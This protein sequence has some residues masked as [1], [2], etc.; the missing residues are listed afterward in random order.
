MKRII[1][2]IIAG[3]VLICSL[4]SVYVEVN[5]FLNPTHRAIADYFWAGFYFI[6]IFGSL[7][8]WWAGKKQY[9]FRTN[10]IF[11]ILLLSVVI[12]FSDNGPALLVLLWLILIAW[13]IGKKFLDIFKLPIE[14]SFGES[15]IFSIG[16]GMIG[17]VLLTLGL[18]SFH[19]LQ[20]FLPIPARF[21]NLLHPIVIFIVLFILSVLFIPNLFKTIRPIFTSAK[22]SFQ[23]LWRSGEPGWVPI[24]F[25]FLSI[26]GI[27]GILLALSPTIRFDALTYHLTVPARYIEARGMVPIPELW[28]SYWAHYAE[29]LYTLAMI[30]VGQPLPSLLHFTFGLLTISLVFLLGKRLG[31]TSVGALAALLFFSIPVVSYEAGTPYIDLMH[32]FYILFAVYAII[33]W[34]QYSQNQWLLIAGI[35]AGFALGIKISTATIVIPLGILMLCAIWIKKH[36]FSQVIKG[37]LH[38]GIMVLVLFSIWLIRDY[39]WTGN[40]I[41]PMY[42]QIFNS[43][44]WVNNANMFTI[45]SSRWSNILSILLMPLDLVINS[46]KYYWEAQ[47]GMLAALPLLSLPWLYIWHPSVKKE[48][49]IISIGLTILLVLSSAFF[50]FSSPN[51][52][53]MI[54]LFTIMAILAA[55]NIKVLFDSFISGYRILGIITVIVFGVYFLSTRLALTVRS[56]DIEERYPVAVAMGFETPEHFLSRSLPNYDTYSY[57]DKK[58]GNHKALAVGTDF[59]FYSKSH[60][61]PSELSVATS[62]LVRENTST[63]KLIQDIAGNGFDYLIVDWN[64]VQKYNLWYIPVLQSSFLN[65][66]TQ[67]EYAQNNVSC[68]RILPQGKVTS[69]LPAEGENLLKNSNFE[70]KEENNNLPAWDT[71]GQPYLNQDKNDVYSGDGDVHVTG[72]DF[73]F[74]E[75]PVIPGEIYTLGYWF[76]GDGNN[77]NARLQIMWRDD[78]LITVKV[79][80]FQVNAGSNWTWRQLSSIAP[81]EATSARVY[82][83][84]GEGSKVWVDDV[85]FTR[86]NISSVSEMR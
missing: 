78:N 39:A 74:Q 18:A 81:D 86:G 84:A 4:I 14:L 11:I 54:P 26:F 33:L 68:Y 85:I 34:W 9:L 2:I 5:T 24:T 29:I 73:V 55:I 44:L 59:S 7:A 49:K 72:N 6:T 10:V 46:K 58:A 21:T 13:S 61:Y 57:L 83:T 51:A 77:Q 28:N 66:F 70:K 62:K 31:G 37:S 48:T 38:F 52:R 45:N 64:G 60:I 40:P 41:F 20:P 79:S 63:E 53:Y 17:L 69:P 25:T 42:N 71:Y 27:A 65:D 30:I 80:S 22:N 23:A 1:T 15:A 56:S 8:F 36:S 76:K 50:L 47:N 35:T 19:L 3:I 75:V 12:L 43:P 67:L 82:V 32:S 16:V